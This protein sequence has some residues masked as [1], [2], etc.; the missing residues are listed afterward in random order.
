MP[1]LAFNL[2]NGNEFVFDLVQDRISLGRSPQ[3]EIVIENI[4]ISSYHAELL[5]QAD[6]NYEIVD[7]RSTLGTFVNGTR[8][9]TVILRPNDKIRFGELDARYREG[10]LTRPVPPGGSA[11]QSLE[12]KMQREGEREDQSGG[13]EITKEGKGSEDARATLESTEPQQERSCNSEAELPKNG[14]PPLRGTPT[15]L[16]AESLLYNP[17][18]WSEP[19]AAAA[20][21]D[22]VGF[23]ELDTSDAREEQLRPAPP[24]VVAG[25]LV[26]DKLHDGGDQA[27][28]DTTEDLLHTGAA[29][30]GT[31][32]DSLL[33]EAPLF[34]P[35]QQPEPLAAAAPED[36]V[37][38]GELDASD[39]REEQLRP[40]ATKE[41]SAVPVSDKM[42]EAEKP[43]SRSTESGLPKSGEAPQPEAA[44]LGSEEPQ[45]S[46]LTPASEPLA[47]APPQDKVS[48]GDLDATGERE[49]LLAPVSSEGA[50]A[51]LVEDKLHHGGDQAG[52]DTEKRIFATE[53]EAAREATA[54]IAAFPEPIHRSAI[55]VAVK[56][57]D[58]LSFRERDAR[59]GGGESVERVVPEE[60]AR[61]EE[62]AAVL[63]AG[64]MHEEESV[65]SDDTGTLREVGGAAQSPPSLSP[66]NVLLPDSTQPSG[67][68]AAVPPDDKVHLGGGDGARPP[69]GSLEALFANP[70]QRLETP[71]AASSAPIMQTL[72]SPPVISSNQI[73]AEV[74]NLPV[75]P[76]PL[77]ATKPNAPEPTHPFVGLE[78]EVKPSVPPSLVT[79]APALAAAMEAWL[80]ELRVRREE[81]R[82]ALA[83]QSKAKSGPDPVGT[84]SAA[85]EEKPVVI[86]SAV[87]APSERVPLER[88]KT[89]LA[90]V[91]LD[92][93]KSKKE[94]ES[95]QRQ[96]AERKVEEL[97]TCEFIAKELCTD[98]R[99][100]AGL[101]KDRKAGL[102]PLAGIAHENVP[103]NPRLGRLM[104]LTI[105]A[106]LLA[107]AGAVFWIHKAIAA[108]TEIR[109][110]AYNPG[111][112][113]A[114]AYP[115]PSDVA[116]AT[117]TTLPLGE[118]PIAPAPS[119][120][121]EDL[122][123]AQR[124]LVLLKERNRL[125]AYADEAIAT[126]V[127]AS[128]DRLWE[129]MVD[130]R[131][132][133]LAHAARAEILR[134]QNTYLS[135]SRI[136][137]FDIPVGAY[138]PQHS[139]LTD[140]QLTDGQLIKLLSDAAKPWEVRMKA[141]NLLGT[142]RSVEVGD[143]LA[144]AVKSDAN[145]DVVKEATF[146]FEQMTG[147]HCKIFDTASLQKWWQEYKA[148][149]ESPKLTTA[150]PP[151]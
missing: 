8:I 145:L 148:N 33:V 111:S 138:F 5:R 76:P 19:L 16:F 78:A 11:T 30:E 89:E 118:A 119:A 39:A 150:V 66:V 17:T 37:G 135:G 101:G 29:P 53:E 82:A 27:S 35:A 128:Y 86:S 80:L 115:Q 1:Y 144:Q 107:L 141:A 92:L 34:D 40:V 15:S 97:G 129:A 73:P 52:R 58:S 23:G 14:E 127:R 22:K 12:D 88:A 18:Q 94:L 103:R 85:M 81:E 24:E 93:E 140:S 20:P 137:R 56:P 143:A 134:V 102:S 91:M 41:D 83:E 63:A 54:S 108:E 90:S 4:F 36:K 136:D 120:L 71:A 67:T 126:G 113:A 38:F 133:N 131:L 106:N 95:V 55:R 72:A 142:R 7:L 75:E 6:G 26:A 70:V 32:A 62:G 121:G 96:L 112:T 123:P 151:P 98:D 46:S 21:E 124:E 114:A 10:E 109:L 99:Y 104:A 47:V 60:C 9:R 61:K 31:T 45:L 44:S 149:P 105:L 87:A 117:T 43:D 59:N 28:R 122:P 2:N 79:K 25:V 48:F 65:Q 84:K 3:N 50:A 51:N 42:H 146:S 100:L 147:Y 77:V 69:S 110:A 132:A 64:K 57:E 130:P 74:V 68:P 49:E 125:T 13:T 139:G 116:P